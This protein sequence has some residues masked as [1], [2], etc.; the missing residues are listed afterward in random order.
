MRCLGSSL[1]FALA[2]LGT[3]MGLASA[4]FAAAPRPTWECL[5]DDTAVMVRM[6]QPAEF[7][8]A[9]RTRTKFGAVALDERRLQG[10]WSVV[11][12][13]LRQEGTEK[14]LVEFEEQL[15]RY[16][17]S[18][19]DLQAAFR[20]DMGAGFVFHRRDEAPEPLV[21]ILAWL[22]PGEETAERLV[23]AVQ[24]K[25][26]EEVTA[27]EAGATKRIDL[28]MAGHDVLWMVEP[29]LGIDAA[30]LDADAGDLDDLDQEALESRLA[31]LREKVRTA[32]RVRTGQTH[33]FLARIGGRLLAGQ[34]VPTLRSATA[35]GRE[36]GDR[37]FD[38]ESGTDEAKAIFERFL[39]EHAESDE[40]PLANVMQ[41]PGVAASLPGGIPLADVIVDPRVLIGAWGDDGIRER[42]ASIGADDL[43]PLAWRQSL[44]DDRYHSGMFLSL[45]APRTSLMRI[46][47]Q[48]CDPSEVPS[49]VTREAIDLTQIS[50]DLGRAYETVKEFA[51]VQGGPETANMFTAIEMQ[52]QGWLGV[53]LPNL[54]ASLGSRHWIVTYP[55]QVAEAF[56]EA[57]KAR[58]QEGV[59]QARQ[60]ADRAAVVWQIDDETPFGKILQRLAG[61]AGGQIEEEQG[62]RGIRIP[63]GPA[64]YLGQGHLVVAIG[65]DSLEK[66]LSA[67]RNPPAGDASFRESDVVRRA[68]EL[69]PLKPGRMFGVSDSARSAGTLG[70][71]RDMM[72][73][74]LPEDVDE[75]YRELLAGFQKLLPSND[76]MEG[77]FGVGA[78]L[79]RAD[80]AGVAVESVWE[81]PAP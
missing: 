66:T 70:V 44:E 17:L 59:I 50:L 81:M 22:E 41:L 61:M 77:M 72:E 33:T 79:I 62:F 31:E 48:D 13:K 37:D 3:V 11:L 23:A 29:L 67:I 1:R 52:A 42:L 76:D 40:S 21:M 27:D 20:G 58:G 24:R 46:L 63:D 78:T 56:A 65:K 18:R 74:M 16:G 12:E 4:G 6:P 30:A 75:A 2:G 71:L 8:E 55:P 19:D 25:V 10:L 15:A 35:R 53:D 69:L 36:D 28:E 26:E 49:F 14:N 60:V 80:D 47:D 38:A 34:T 5:P 45:P 57:R 43:G 54:L 68:G 51:V 7:L 32:K 64:V 39:A 73:A 9:V